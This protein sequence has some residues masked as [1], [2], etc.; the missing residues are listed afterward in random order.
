MV[1][2]RSQA[3]GLLPSR[4][5]ALEIGVV[6]LGL[7]LAIGLGALAVS[8]LVGRLGRARGRELAPPTPGS[9][10]PQRHRNVAAVSTR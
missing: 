7:T 10:P 8:E 2:V 9:L 1:K 4:E 5:A 6:S 3:V